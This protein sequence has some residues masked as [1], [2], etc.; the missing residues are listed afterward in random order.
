M[1]CQWAELSVT[2][3][4]PFF[5][6]SSTYIDSVDQWVRV[7][8]LPCKLWDHDTLINLLKPVGNVIKVYQTT[9]FYLKGKFARACVNIDITEPL[10]GSLVISFKGK[11][12]KVSSFM[13]AFMSSMPYVGQNPIKLNQALICLYNL[14]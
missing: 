3:W 8:R 11:S 13:M 6:P 9:L 2:P 14:K 1:A 12:M 10:S 4:L 7:P 5:D